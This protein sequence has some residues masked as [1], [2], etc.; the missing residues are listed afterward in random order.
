MLVSAISNTAVA[1]LPNK[2][3]RH[4][5]RH[6]TGRSVSHNCQLLFLEYL[7]VN[8]SWKMPVTSHGKDFPFYQWC[9]FCWK[10]LHVWTVS[11]NNTCDICCTCKD[12]NLTLLTCESFSVHYRVMHTESSKSTKEAQEVLKMTA[13]TTLEKIITWCTT[14]NVE[15]QHE[16]IVS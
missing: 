9:W 12:N 13:R 8:P 1:I 4:D 10:E 3:Y 15:V 14:D 5:S 11:A 16:L 2:H 7:T 6:P